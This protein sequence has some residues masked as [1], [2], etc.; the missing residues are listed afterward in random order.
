MFSGAA[1][2]DVPQFPKYYVPYADV[3]ADVRKKAKPLSALIGVKPG[4][5]AAVE[6]FVARSG[7]AEGDFAYVPLT[8]RGGS[9][10]AVV[11][12]RDARIIGFI[13]IDP[14]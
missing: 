13:P 4:G 6:A 9:V 5:K 3:A 12:A 7:R 10:T 1:G 14:E 2:K 11:D 8:G